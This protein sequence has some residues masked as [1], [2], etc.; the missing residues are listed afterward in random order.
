MRDQ[1][2]GSSDSA[3]TLQACLLGGAMGDSLGA[4]IEFHSLAAI[5]ARFPA[6]LADLPPYGG[7]RGAI[8]DDTQMTFFT[9]EGLIRARIRGQLRGICHPRTETDDIGLIEDRRLWSEC[10]PGMTCM[11]ALGTSGRFGEPA[12]NDSKGCGTIM[13]VAPVAL[14]APRDQV[15]EWAIETSAL[16]HGHVTGQ[17]AAAAWAEMLADVAAGE[18][19]ELAAKRIATDYARLDGGDETAH[20]IHAVLAAAARREARNRRKPGWRL[21]GR[22]GAGHRALRL[23]PRERPG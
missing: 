5:Q 8:T 10:A 19:L 6:G 2:T 21:D 18:P 20:A 4:D 14:I 3:K 22:R 11:A 9:A 16:T 17:L 15:R 1:A 7:Q 23:P 12:R 13:R